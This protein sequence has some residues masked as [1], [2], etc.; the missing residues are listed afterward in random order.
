MSRMQSE[1]AGVWNEISKMEQGE[2]IKRT[3]AKLHQDT[4]SIRFSV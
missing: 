2:I 4:N 3:L 1:D